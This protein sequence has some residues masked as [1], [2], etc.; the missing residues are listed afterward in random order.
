M[1]KR[2]QA[3]NCGVFIRQAH[4]FCVMHWTMLDPDVQ[5]ELIAAYTPGQYCDN[6][7]KTH[8]WYQALSKARY[9]IKEQE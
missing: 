5:D 8:K 2:C 3:R 7:L 9:V 1:P 6:Q 4:T